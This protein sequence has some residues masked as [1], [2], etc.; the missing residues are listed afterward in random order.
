[1]ESVS[2]LPHDEFCSAAVFSYSRPTTLSN[3]QSVSA[4]A[5]G[6]DPVGVHMVTVTEDSVRRRSGLCM[7]KTS[8]SPDD[9]TAAH[10]AQARALSQAK[11][12]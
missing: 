6:L 1:M 5:G 3:M 11:L 2:S 4:T 10:S 12:W 7:M 8:V 9:L